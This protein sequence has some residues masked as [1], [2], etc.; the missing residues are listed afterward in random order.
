MRRIYESKALRRDDDEPFSPRE[1]DD[2]FQPQAIRSI[3]STAWSR[4]LV[5]HW[6]RHR[7][8]AVSIST[9]QREY[10]PG[11][12]VP[13]TVTMK[14][15][16]PFPITIE[17]RSPVLWTWDVD[18]ATE[19]SRVATRDPPDDPHGFEFDRGERKRFTRRW[20][21]MFRVSDSEWEPAGPGEY[22]IGAG[23]NVEGREESS[24]YDE[25]TI[26][27]RED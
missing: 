13:F 4:R 3:N 14:N 7:S 10:A 22:T 6:L 20:Q 24:L 27:V 16:M 1:R 21:Q 15:V 11:D 18:R 5:P 8:I 2:Q 9:R 23:I 25:T 19:G 17:T 12:A 26:R